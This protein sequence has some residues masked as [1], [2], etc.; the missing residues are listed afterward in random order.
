MSTETH[1]D[2][3][4]AS[5]KD[6]NFKDDNPKKNTKKANS[7]SD[8]PTYVLGKTTAKVNKLFKWIFRTVYLVTLLSWIYWTVASDRYVSE[9]VVLV[10]NTE[11]GSSASPADLLSMFSG[12]SGNKVDQLLLVEFLTSIDMLNKLDEELNLRE[13]YSSDHIDPISRLWS[14]DVSAE[15][16]YRY[17]RNRVTV[18]YDDYS[19]VV[20]ISA[21]AFDPVMAEKITES[22]VHN[23][24]NFMN[25]LSHKIADEQVA[26]LSEQVNLARNDLLKSNEKLLDFQN[27][28]NMVSPKAEVEN[29]QELIAGLE[30]QKSELLVKISTLPANLGTNNQ[31]KQTLMAN[32]KAIDEQIMFL[33]KSVTNA[34]DKVNAL[35]ELAYEENLLKL[36]AE[37]KKD[38]YSSTLSGLAKGKLSAARM[39]KNVGIL[40]APSKPQYAIKPERLYCIIATLVVMLLVLGMLQLLKAVILDHVD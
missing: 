30:K 5:D 14:K 38:I 17:Y 2:K 6:Q 16:F 34:G 23:G 27:R 29:H 7:S 35:N 40:Q 9:A 11:N 33:R 26:F 39:I 12:G 32:I 15:W 37:F 28:K 24:E 36:D 25:G 21:Q 31:I 18:V 20:R 10:Q 22:L 8:G 19:G 13:H 4:A 3:T 1:T